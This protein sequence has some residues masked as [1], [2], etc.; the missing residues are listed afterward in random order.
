M[1]QHSSP[2]K[3]QSSKEDAKASSSPKN[4][5]VPPPILP[6]AAP[7][8]RKLFPFGSHSYGNKDQ[9][10]SSPV[11]KDKY[12]NQRNENPQSFS[13]PTT[14]KHN[15]HMRKN[16]VYPQASKV[17]DDRPSKRPCLFL[18]SP[19]KQAE[20][21]L[22]AVDKRP[23]TEAESD[24]KDGYSTPSPKS[25]KRKAKGHKS[26]SENSEKIPLSAA[27]PSNSNVSVIIPTKKSPSP[28]PSST[29]PNSAAIFQ[30]L[31]A[32][33]KFEKSMLQRRIDASEEEARDAKQNAEEWSTKYKACASAH[34]QLK[35]Q[36]ESQSQRQPSSNSVLARLT[37]LHQEISNL[38]AEKSSI[39][40]QKQERIAHLEAASSLLATQ[41]AHLQ[42][43]AQTQLRHHDQQAQEI[44][45]LQDELARRSSS[46]SPSTATPAPAPTHEWEQERTQLLEELSFKDELASQAQRTHACETS[47][48]GEQIA[49]LRA[50]L[51]EQRA[52]ATDSTDST[53]QAAQTNGRI[54]ALMADH[55][56]VVDG[57]QRACRGK[58]ER[59]RR[60]EILVAGWSLKWHAV[61]GEVPGVEGVDGVKIRV[62]GVEVRD[63][64][65]GG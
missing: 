52:R 55:A 26:T 31:I 43:D 50:Q 19:T 40:T 53:D 49:D 9:A 65:M 10:F 29:Q 5:R 64:G 37:E 44:A 58:D 35:S 36:L 56:Q 7:T 24:D 30:P 57:L 62:Q 15:H 20:T 14:K 17:S 13:S 33:L 23:R 38:K 6:P 22:H 51:E 59:L 54:E 34:D 1:S 28:P 27:A 12:P 61:V 8:R 63:M 45:R 47:R 60:M 32:A 41:I 2:H 4:A 39:L 42:T 3:F 21:N 11:K 25:R 46:P 48:L 16:D 18:S